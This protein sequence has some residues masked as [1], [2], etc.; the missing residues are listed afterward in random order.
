[1]VT[2]TRYA[3]LSYRVCYYCTT[4]QCI[5]YCRVNNAK[6][7][8]APFNQKGVAPGTNVKGNVVFSI[9]ATTQTSHYAPV[10]QCPSIRIR[11]PPSPPAPLVKHGRPSIEAAHVSTCRRAP[12]LVSEGLRRRRCQQTAIFSILRSKT[13]RTDHLGP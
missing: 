2:H 11:L 10:L 6:C 7:S 5:G 9:S 4:V 3:Y 12:T 13:H 8:S 1:M